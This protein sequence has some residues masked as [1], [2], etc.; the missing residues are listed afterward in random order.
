MDEDVS[1]LSPIKLCW[2]I[3]VKLL[4]KW[5]ERSARGRRSVRMV[6]ADERDHRIEA[7]IKYKDIFRFD[8]KFK[9]GDW[10]AIH[11]FLLKTVT[12]DRRTTRHDYR[13]VF[14][15]TTILNKISPKDALE[16]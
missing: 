7:K 5:R 1:D 10:V 6:L 9:D 2:S 16:H 4:N 14:L 8:S 3:Q 15:E 11:H 12:E 13:I